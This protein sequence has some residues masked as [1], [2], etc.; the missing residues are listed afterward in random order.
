[1]I[2]AAADERKTAAACARAL[3]N[4]HNFGGSFAISSFRFV[5]QNLHKL[6]IK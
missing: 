1:M 3:R 5:V 2:A 6:R 4:R